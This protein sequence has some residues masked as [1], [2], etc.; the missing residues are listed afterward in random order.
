MN[1]LV[2]SGNLSKEPELRKTLSGTSVASSTIAV[3]R[4][5]KNANGEKETDFIDFSCFGQTADYLVKYAHKGD[6]GELSGR[7]ESRKY[8]DKNGNTRVVWEMI[9]EQVTI[10]NKKEES[11][12]PKPITPENAYYDVPNEDD[13][14]F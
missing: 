10:F 8:T 2:V 5:R 3:N 11:D 6:R 9:A 4:A 14:P 7:L 12:K 13:L 1:V